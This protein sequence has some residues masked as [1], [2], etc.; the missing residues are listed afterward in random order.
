MGLNSYGQITQLTV[1]K[2]EFD[3][4][5]FA[6]PAFQPGLVVFN[7]GGRTPGAI[8]IDCVRQMVMFIDTEG[9]M[10]DLVDND[11]V[12]R[13]AIGKKVFYHFGT[14]FVELVEV[15]EDMVGL[16][17]MKTISVIDEQ[18]KGAYGYV[19][20]TTN[21]T[22][23]GSVYTGGQFYELKDN[24]EVPII[25]KFIPYIYRDERF[26][27]ASKKAFEK[28]FPA[29]KAEIAEYLKSNKVDF[30]NYSQVE[31]LFNAIK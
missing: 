12:A 17:R 19:S 21:I 1:K 16:G 30:E 2:A 4:I 20:Q 13:I 26:T 22:T 14:D 11:K 9:K 8:N 15:N 25:Q 27:R 31:A 29:K 23:I 28:A 10:Q 7:D 18:K 5:H 6:V 24:E 3:S